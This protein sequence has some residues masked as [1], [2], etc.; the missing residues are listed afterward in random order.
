MW[1]Y[2]AVCWGAF[3]LGWVI[4]GRAGP[5]GVPRRLTGTVSSLDPR[6]IKLSAVALAVLGLTLLRWTSIL[7]WPLIFWLGK[8]LLH[9]LS[10]T[11]GLASPSPQLPQILI[12]RP[13]RSLRR[14][15]LF[16]RWIAPALWQLGQPIIPMDPNS[17]FASRMPSS[18]GLT[19]HRYCFYR[20]LNSKGTSWLQEIRTLIKSSDVIVVDTSVFRPAV[21][22]EL[23]LISKDETSMSRLILIHELHISVSPEESRDLYFERVGEEISNAL[24]DSF[25]YHPSNTESLDTLWKSVVHRSAEIL[26][27]PTTRIQHYQA[28][29]KWMLSGQALSF[30]ITFKK[31]SSDVGFSFDNTIFKQATQK[32][33]DCARAL[34]GSIGGMNVMNTKDRE[35]KHL[36]TMIL[37]DPPEDFAQSFSDDWPDKELIV[38]QA[39]RRIRE[40]RLIRFIG[41]GFV[42]WT[43]FNKMLKSVEA[44]ST[45]PLN[46]QRLLV[47]YLALFEDI[48][49]VRERVTSINP[50]LRAH[51]YETKLP[52][53]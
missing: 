3:L 5:V 13:Y 27:I 37:L 32:D 11:S 36:K 4:I 16:Q 14:D 8:I 41:V 50:Q 25:S 31:G 22:T 17:E 2:M 6:H 7:V 10:N 1:V 48:E 46:A 28:P 44:F 20:R 19:R 9:K 23:D 21:A 29:R 47:C 24:R 45:D 51:L 43:R 18:P 40:N 30:A 42:N 38:G 12:L 35:F 26:Q 39:L 53:F 33:W 49:K 34:L 52:T 15:L